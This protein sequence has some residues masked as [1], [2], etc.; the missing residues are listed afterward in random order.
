MRLRE[1]LSSVL[2]T[3]SGSLLLGCASPQPAPPPPQETVAKPQGILGF[4]E[5]VQ[6]LGKG[7]LGQMKRGSGQEIVVIDPFVDVDSG[8]QL[9][10]NQGIGKAISAAFKP[11]YD[12]RQLTPEDFEA[13]H[14]VLNGIIANED[15]KAA[16]SGK[17]Y[18]IYASIFGGKSGKVEAATEVWVSR[19]EYAPEDMYAESPVYLRD[20]NLENQIA[21]AK[22]LPGE[23]VP[24][25]Y[26]RHLETKA[27]IAQGDR[28][29][30]EKRYADALKSYE[31]AEGRPDGKTV[32]V[33]SGLYNIHRRLGD[34]AAAEKA[35]GRLA[36]VSVDEYG[37]IDVKLLFEVNAATFAQD[38]AVTSQYS[39]WLRQITR[40]IME[41]RRCI[42]IVGHCSRS[43]PEA[44]NDQLSERRAKAVQ[45]I[46][47]QTDPGILKR[48][49]AKGMGFRL[50][51]VGTG[52]DDQ[53]DAIDRRVE[54][55]ITDCANLSHGK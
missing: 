46:M 52:A 4:D 49:T 50:N 47:A 5:A 51:I 2:V 12:V 39:I 7:L 38:G 10:I 30:G 23:K 13:A 29:Y 45:K 31:A 20:R 24:E 22:S 18:H 34:M 40:L 26:V 55:L 54:F 25:A 33:Y 11:Q 41:S 14:Y 35:F 6:Y 44:Y 21:S 1:I 19:I 53:S 32:K 16:P 37:R 9:K 27:L 15:N 36:A 17:A 3:I 43:G 42:Q 48:S 28:Q 8:Q